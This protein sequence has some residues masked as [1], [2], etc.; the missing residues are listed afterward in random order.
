MFVRAEQAFRSV[1]LHLIHHRKNVR[2]VV[3]AEVFRICDDVSLPVCHDI[4]RVLLTRYVTLRLRIWAK[5]QRDL[6]KKTVKTP[7]ENGELGSKSMAMRMAVK[8]FK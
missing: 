4:K 3:S 6:L 2:K 5:D 8:K 7:A 1:N